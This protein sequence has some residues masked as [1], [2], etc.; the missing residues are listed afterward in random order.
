MKILTK[1]LIFLSLSY[2]VNAISGQNNIF[3]LKLWASKDDSGFL[4]IH[5]ESSTPP[6]RNPLIPETSIIEEETQTW[7]ESN[8]ITIDIIPSKY[9]YNTND[10]VKYRWIVTGADYVKLVDNVNYYN[11]DITMLTNT[12]DLFRQP[13]R[14]PSYSYEVTINAYNLIERTKKSKTIIIKNKTNDSLPEEVVTISKPEVAISETNPNGEVIIENTESIPIFIA[15]VPVSG[16]GSVNEATNKTLDIN[17]VKDV[18]GVYP[19]TTETVIIEIQPGGSETITF[20]LDDAELPT[21]TDKFYDIVLLV[22]DTP[23]GFADFS[24]PPG[25]PPLFETMITV[26]AVKKGTILETKPVLDISNPV[27]ESMIEEEATT[28]YADGGVL[29][30]SFNNAISLPKIGYTDLIVKNTGTKELTYNLEIGS[31]TDER[32]IID[33]VKEKG[34]FSISNDLIGRDECAYNAT[35]TPSDGTKDPG[36]YHYRSRGI[37]QPGESQTIRYESDWASEEFAPSFQKAGFWV[38]LSHDWWSWGTG[39]WSINNYAEYPT[40]YPCS[41][42]IDV[43]F[44]AN[45]TDASGDS[46]N[47]NFSVARNF[48]NEEK[49]TKSIVEFLQPMSKT[50]DGN[51]HK[52]NKINSKSIG[53]GAYPGFGDITSL[54][55]DTPDESWSCQI[56]NHDTKPMIVLPFR[57][58]NYNNKTISVD[59][60]ITN[61][62]A[63]DSEH[64]T[65]YIKENFSISANSLITHFLSI[66][67]DKEYE[68]VKDPTNNISLTATFEGAFLSNNIKEKI[69]VDIS[70]DLDETIKGECY[71]ASDFLSSVSVDYDY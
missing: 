68:Q 20:S 71:Y 13:G 40:F 37:L 65:T 49:W 26:V 12:D 46:K 1:L 15:V 70:F 60:S 9:S 8:S 35:V 38:L 62:L 55:L 30:V 29:N 16:S 28:P 19:S 45:A 17:E 42:N 59:A 63:K 21:D 27:E 7:S 61:N 22:F 3:Q 57:I 23:D 44:T 11:D 47:I 31:E 53:F 66:E 39:A 56:V 14:M 34:Y 25:K 48:S 4:R 64:V 24:Q 52:L 10:T 18:D 2:S 67:I 69:S 51:K 36:F 54:K 33:A 32:A 41:K 5:N 58:N 43:N 6:A 50:K